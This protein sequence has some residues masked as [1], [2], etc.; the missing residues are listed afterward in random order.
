MNCSPACASVNTT[1]EVYGW[2]AP[3]MVGQIT[4]ARTR[5]RCGTAGH[6]LL[7]PDKRVTNPLVL[8]SDNDKCEPGI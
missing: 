8:H 4:W 3:L 2:L 7:A 5:K 6:E 1:V